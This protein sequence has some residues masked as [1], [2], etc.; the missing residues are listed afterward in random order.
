MFV[1][2]PL[3]LNMQ[4]HHSVK[5][6]NLPIADYSYCYLNSFEDISC[7][8]KN[9]HCDLPVLVSVKE[10]YIKTFVNC[11]ASVICV[12]PEPL[13]INVYLSCCAIVD[14]QCTH[15]NVY[16]RTPSKS[17]AEPSAA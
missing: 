8:I 10:H 17:I 11:C 1:S 2:K 5:L 14:Q 7:S 16:I 6:V 4:I 3:H 15:A 13:V 9:I 12:V